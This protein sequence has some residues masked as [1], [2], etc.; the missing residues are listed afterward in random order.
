MKIV[1]F[2]NHYSYQEVYFHTNNPEYCFITKQS[3]FNPADGEDF[4]CK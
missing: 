4:N 3:D 1:I 2:P